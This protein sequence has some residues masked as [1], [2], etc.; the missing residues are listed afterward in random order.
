[1]LGDG[2]GMLDTLETWEREIGQSGAKG[3]AIYLMMAHWVCLRSFGRMLPQ[4]L[5]EVLWYVLCV[6]LLALL[7]V[8]FWMIVRLRREGWFGYA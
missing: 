2:K 6:G 5:L 8:A 7:G 3:Y 4:R 1:M